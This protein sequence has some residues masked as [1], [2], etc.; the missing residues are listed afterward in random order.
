MNWLMK[1]TMPHV[2]AICLFPFG[3][4][5][6][7]IN[8]V[9]KYIDHEEVHW[10]QQ[11]EMLCIPFYIWY[12]IEWLIKIP[13]CKRKAYKSISFEQEARNYCPCEKKRFG[14]LRYVFSC[15]PV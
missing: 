7:N 9:L 4:Y 2:A 12:L 10:M 3:I 13:F 11:K 5:F 8:D 15:S 6:R 1:F 14:W